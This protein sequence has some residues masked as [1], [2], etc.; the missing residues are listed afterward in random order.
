MKRLIL[1]VALMICATSAF[2]QQ[3][4]QGTV[5]DA[6][7]GERLPWCSIAVKG[8]GKGTITNSEGIFRLILIPGHDTLV[9][10]YVGYAR[11]QLPVTRLARDPVIK[12][13]RAGIQLAELVIHANDEYLYKILEKCRQR[14]LR[15][16]RNHQAKVYYGISTSTRE[17]PIELVE[18][19]YNGYL[20]G[21]SVDSLLFRNGRVGCAELDQRYFLTLN[22]SKAVS[23][24]SLTRKY[25]DPHYPI[26]PLQ[27]TGKALR[28]AYILTP[29]KSS[30]DMVCIGFRPRSGFGKYFSGS[31]WIDLE[32]KD[33]VKIKLETVN[34][35]RHPFAPIYP[36]DRLD[37][38]NL[39]I[40]ET[41]RKTETGN[42]LEQVRF[43]YS[44]TYHTTRTPQGV[45]TSGNSSSRRIETHGI[46]FLYDYEEPFILPRFDYFSEYDDY[47]KMSIIPFNR[48]FWSTSQVLVLSE[49]QKKELGFFTGKGVTLNFSESG[50]GRDFL[51]QVHYDSSLAKSYY[52]FWDSTRQITLN[53]SLPRNREYSPIKINGAIRTDLYRL[54]VQLLL[55]VTCINDSCFC[56]SYTVFDE[57]RS[58][59]HLPWEAYTGTFIN[60]YFD[61]YEKER[62]KMQC[63]LDSRK[64]TAVQVDSVYQSTLKSAKAVTNRYL[65]EVKTGENKKALEKWE[66]VVRK[67]LG[68]IEN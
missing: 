18:C 29:E 22:T 41:F 51:E 11:L 10:T 36:G 24:L 62:R 52:T 14:I 60:L 6:R 25:P 39:S 61:L 53:R 47:H 58:M 17:Q 68:K 13:N 32:T 33:I 48:E 64:W 8:T 4:V 42:T 26:I 54:E 27:L 15:D 38:V 67:E 23:Q 20:K 19:Y 30:S 2:T 59:F 44:L 34:T 21:I 12:L 57:W 43:S 31:V 40:N 37:E 3:T 7:T 63:V 46:L 35:S 45:I 65:G 55:D 28:N 1:L 9:I 56:R 50:H 5:T 16:K 49:E 66:E